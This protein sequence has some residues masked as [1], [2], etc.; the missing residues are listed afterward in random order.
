MGYVPLLLLLNKNYIYNSDIAYRKGLD[1]FRTIVQELIK[2]KINLFFISS[3]PQ[4]DRF[5]PFSMIQ[6]DLTYP[7][8][9]VNIQNYKLEELKTSNTK[10]FE[11]I[12]DIVTKEGGVVIDPYHYLCNDGVCPVASDV[13]IPFY[14]D[15][16]HFTTQYVKAK[17]EYLDFLLSN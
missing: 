1:N 13:G 3:F 7:F 6:R 10:F 2:N 17:V 12:N 15:E 4:G 5:S 11:E 16:S 8:Y 9:R 14:R